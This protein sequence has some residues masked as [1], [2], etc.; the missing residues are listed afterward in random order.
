MSL[1]PAAISAKPAFR[2]V[3]ASHKHTGHRQVLKGLLEYARRGPG[4]TMQAK[5]DY[6]TDKQEPETLLLVRR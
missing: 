6:R 5:P 2:T 1:A 4:R 3:E